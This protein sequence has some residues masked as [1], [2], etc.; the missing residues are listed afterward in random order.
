[1]DYENQKREDIV[2]LARIALTGRVSD[3]QLYVR[4]LSR[5]YKDVDAELS[6]LLTGLLR[7]SPI[8]RSPA[9]RVEPTT[10]PLDNES[11]LPLLRLLETPQLDAEP[12]YDDPTWRSLRQIVDEHKCIDRLNASGIEPTR[13]ALFTG[14]PGVGK[15]LAA[16]WIAREL[17]RPLATLDLSAVMSS[18]LGRTGNNVRV[19]LDYAKAHDCV[20]LLDE[21]DAVAK[22]RDDSTEIGELKR[23]VTVLLQE[24]D[25]WPAG[26]LLLAATNHPDLL[27]SAV[28]RRFEV[29]VD[30]PKPSSGHLASALRDLLDES[31][32][33]PWPDILGAAFN[34]FSYSDA[35][36]RV[37]GAR[38]MAALNGGHLEENLASIVQDVADHLDRDARHD[39]A[40]RLMNDAGLSQRQA[41]DITG[42]SRD[43]IRKHTARG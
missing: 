23:L 36:Q 38:R 13:S 33:S 35:A 32:S 26:G 9:R 4:K 14:P 12:V 15:T 16:K 39:L 3:V 27:D 5:R 42:V 28:W 31:A 37:K 2:H 40:R 17:A 7:Q 11:R 24:I 20:L 1:M 25:E 21:L 34:G 8:R 19:V 30:F 43:T 18:F 41:S 10:L 29:V 22:R 6:G